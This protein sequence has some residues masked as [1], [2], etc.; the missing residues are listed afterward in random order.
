MVTCALSHLLLLF[1]A[2]LPL[3]TVAQTSGSS[4]NLGDSLSTDGTSLVSPSGDFAFGFYRLQDEDLFLLAIWFDKIPEKTIVWSAKVDTPVPRGSK[5]ELRTD[6]QLVLT[7]QQNQEIW[8]ANGINGTAARA[9]MLNNGNF[10]LTRTDS[11]VVWQSFNNPTDTILPEQVLDKSGR[12]ASHET[13]TNYSSGRFELRMQDDGNLVL[14]TVERL[15]RLAYSAYWNSKTVGNGSQLVFNQ[16]GYIYLSLTN[17]TVFNLT[18]NQVSI[19]SGGFYHRATL[20][21]DGVF[22]QYIYPKTRRTDG[23]WEQSWSSVQFVPSNICT[24]II[25]AVG[26]GACGFNSY[27]MLEGERQRPSCKCPPGYTYLDQN[28]TF[29]GCKQDF[30]SQS[31]EMDGLRAEARYE[32]VQ[33]MNTDWPLSD[34]EHYNPINEDQ[35][36]DACLVDCFC[37]VAIFRGGQCWKK[38]L[39]LS[40]GMMDPDNGS[41]ALIKVARG[42]STS[43]PLPPPGTSK[44][45]KDEKTVVPIIS[46]I[47][48]S[49]AFLNFFLLSLILWFIF[50]T[51]HKKLVKL[52]PDSS[53]IGVNLRSFTYIELEKVTDGFKEEL[54]R[55]SCGTVYK[56]LLESDRANFVAVKRLDKVVKEAEK[57]FKTEVSAISRIHH[58]NLV[59]LIGF[60]DEG[61]HRLLVYEYMSNGSL[62]SFLFGSPRPSW[63]RRTQIAFGIARGLTYLHEECGNQIIHCDI[64]PQNILLDDNFTARISDFGLAKL[65]M[66]NQTRTTTCIRGTRGYL[67]PEWFKNMAV[68]AKVDVHSFGVMLLEIICCRSNVLHDLEDGDDAILTD[69][70]CDCYKEGR[71]DKLVENDEEALHDPR[72]LERMLMVAIW[73]IQEDPSLRPSMKKVTQMLEGAVEV[74]VPPDPFSFISSLA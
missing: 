55:G 65:L 48:G 57:E 22:R 31:C 51:N 11:T 47:L 70:V 7:N 18:N 30:I 4:I 45:K 15:T 19:P 67:A 33:V 2:L 39:P 5:V 3:S 50:F 38:K 16:T 46:A 37:A 68:T 44:E 25:G 6:G 40:N 74:A 23:S 58:K 9:A 29:K 64:K 60:C 61:P 42:N 63:N 12:L 52:Q 24:A 56:G 20:D 54:G 34:F 66:T 10:V 26:D 32:M 72:K 59:Q 53:A 62:A 8:R 43:P 21:F 71:I 28:N 69:W 1:L 36:R 73:C 49:S 14:Y 27:C 35:C 41:K 13:E 17:G